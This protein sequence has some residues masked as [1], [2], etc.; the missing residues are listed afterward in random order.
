M[1]TDG[2]KHVVQ[3]ASGAFAASGLAGEGL[4]NGLHAEAARRAEAKTLQVVLPSPRPS[5]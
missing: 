3:R 5:A 4:V 2:Y 1:Y